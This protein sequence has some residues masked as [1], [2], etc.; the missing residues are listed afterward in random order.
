[1]NELVLTHEALASSYEIIRIGVWMCVQGMRKESK[2]AK[3]GGDGWG[4]GWKP[5][6]KKKILGALLFL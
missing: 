1:M 5:T 3:G 4:N 2:L 6:K